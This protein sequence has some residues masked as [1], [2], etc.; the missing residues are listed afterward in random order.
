[1]IAEGKHLCD[2]NMKE[3]SYFC[4]GGSRTAHRSRRYLQPP[5]NRPR[6]GR[7]GRNEEKKHIVYLNELKNKMKRREGS[8]R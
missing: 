2:E 5:E 4:N 3:R 8:E 7:G 6:L 1:L